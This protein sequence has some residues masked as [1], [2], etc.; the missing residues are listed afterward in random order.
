MNWY[1]MQ[2][3]FFCLDYNSLARIDRLGEVI[4][5]QDATKVMIDHHLYPDNF[6]DFVLS[7]TSASSTC[8]LIFDFICL[9]DEK[10]KLD[11]DIGE[12]IYTGILT[13]TGSFKYSTSAKLFHI[14]AELKE[15]GIDDNRIQDRIFNCQDEKRLRLLGHC[16]FHRMEILEEYN[17]GII[18]LTRKD[19][20]FYNIQRGD[21]EGIVNYFADA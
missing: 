8:E 13:D 15:I 11:L 18:W 6:A 3:L 17:T 12:A 16:L 5:A 1:K 10:S 9:M 21:T 20:E 19:Y 2:I 7:D 14:V 4:D